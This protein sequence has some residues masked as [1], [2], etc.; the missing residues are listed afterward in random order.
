LNSTERR[1]LK[2]VFT[3]SD[4]G[5]KEYI[6]SVISQ[7]KL[8]SNVII[9]GFVSNEEIHT[10]YKNAIA[11]VMPTFL[12]PTNMPVLEAAS[13]GTAVICSNLSGHRESCG[14]GA[15]YV[16]PTDQQGWSVA[17]REVLN[18]GSR[19]ALISR[20]NDVQANSEFNI[21]GAIHRLENVFLKYIP[22]RKAFY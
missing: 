18:D 10:L 5:N 8:E 6:K 7:N 22:V 14:E 4:K 1:D 3:G 13:L 21:R 16:N 12:G 17:M 20:A 15:I 2:L 11:L 9:L 19:I